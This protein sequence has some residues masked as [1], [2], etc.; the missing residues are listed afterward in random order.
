MTKL[1]TILT[2]ATFI[3]LGTVSASEAATLGGR[4]YA[5]GGNVSVQVLGGTAGLTSYLGLYSPV[6]I[7]PI[8]S[9]R[10]VG[11]VVNLGKFAPG[12]ELIF[13]ISAGGHTFFTGPGKRNPDGLPHAVVDLIGPGGVKVGFEDLFGGGDLDYDDN[14]FMF[15]GGIATTQPSV[16]P[17]L[18]AFKL[19]GINANHTIYEGESVS[20]DLLATD[21]N[22]QAITFLLD[23]AIAGKDNRTSGTRS[24]KKDLGTF[25]DEGVFTYSAQ[26]KDKA[27]LSSNTITRTLNV[28]NADPA[29][30]S[31]TEDF[32]IRKNTLFD[33]AA[34][35]TDPGI[36]DILTY[37]WDLNGDSIFDDYL[38]NSG[39][40]SFS[41]SGI[42][43]ITVQ[44]SDGDGGYTY[45]SIQVE[46]V[47]EPTSVLSLL[48][49]GT[50]GTM[51]LKRKQQK[52]SEKLGAN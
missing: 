29:I 31:I 12:Q 49:F 43:S 19:N 6:L 1:S 11:K 17:K 18:T 13:G 26:A 41:T 44:V 21:L 16:A 28:L 33:F 47:P 2:G 40:S 5:T 7:N 3:L 25:V 14:N 15:R 51:L 48:A 46:T 35:A 52:T 10:G 37:Q 38:G 50:F 32:V 45:G 8:A 20:I 4:L 24:V 42:H 34:I 36:N 39:Q 22:P 23:D 27:G 30:A 9:N